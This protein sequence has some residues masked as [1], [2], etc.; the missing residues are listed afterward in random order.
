MIAPCL[1][2]RPDSGETFGDSTLCLILIQ[3][4][5]HNDH[6][7]KR[8]DIGSAAHNSCT[9]SGNRSDTS[10]C[11]GGGDGAGS[12]GRQRAGISSRTRA[13]PVIPVR[14]TANGLR[15]AGS[16]SSGIPVVVFVRT[17]SWRSLRSRRSDWARAVPVIIMRVASDGC[18][19]AGR[20]RLGLTLM[21]VSFTS[22]CHSHGG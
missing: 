22:G 17:I 7:T 21:V 9:S 18:G 16:K 11:R 14:V 4:C 2:C 15:R 1:Q 8:Q 5:R 3:R 13:M 19:R 10:S 12:R 6:N 20:K